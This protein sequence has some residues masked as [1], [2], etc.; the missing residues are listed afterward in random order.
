M[1]GPFYTSQFSII[2]LIISM[3]IPLP[4]LPLNEEELIISMNTRT[5]RIPPPFKLANSYLDPYNTFKT[6]LDLISSSLEPFFKR[7]KASEAY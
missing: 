7:L 2:L 1:T 5:I 6:P 3:K 4:I